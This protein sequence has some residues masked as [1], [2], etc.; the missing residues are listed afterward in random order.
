MYPSVLANVECMQMQP[1]RTHLQNQRIDE[2]PSNA[3]SAIVLEGSTQCFQVANEV[4]DRAVSR[5][6]LCQFIVC[7]RQ[8]VWHHG[9][10]RAFTAGM[11]HRPAHTRLHADDEAPVVL[12]LVLLAEDLRLRRVHLRNVGLETS[13]QLSAHGNL[14][15]ASGQQ[16]HDLF[17]LPLIKQQQM[18]ARQL[19]CVARYLRRDKRVAVAIAANP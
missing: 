19:D 2:R 10:R 17:K 6:G 18:S 12:V 13:Q 8:R 9:Q 14:L 7:L 1:E 15:S 16:V 3:Q 4:R 5:Q 11:L